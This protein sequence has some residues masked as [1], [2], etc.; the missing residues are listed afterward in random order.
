MHSLVF[1][2]FFYEIQLEFFILTFLPPILEFVIQSVS[3][4]KLFHCDITSEGIFTVNFP[5]LIVFR[6]L[7]DFW[8]MPDRYEQSLNDFLMHFT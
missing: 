6:R 7:Q 2:R 5:S 3:D 8:Q 4:R 1:W